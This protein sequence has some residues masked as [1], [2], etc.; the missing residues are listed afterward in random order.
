[1]PEEPLAPAD[2]DRLRRIRRRF[3]E[4]ATEYAALPL[5]ATVCREVARDEATASLL[6]AARPGQARPVLFLAALHELVLRRPDVAAAQWFPSVTGASGTVTGDPWPDVRRTVLAHADE[7]R[8]RIATHGTQTNE[9]NR[10]VYVAL[11]L[12]A[13]A[14]DRPGVPVAL[15]ELGASAGLLLGVDRYRVELV[16][17]GDPEPGRGHRPGRP[18]VVVGDEG[19]TVRCSGVDRAGAGEELAR[20]GLALPPVRG[21]VG[22]DLAPVDLADDDGVRWL[23]ACLWPEVPGRVERFRAAR[24]LLQ[25]DPPRVLRGDMV[26]R[27]P[28]AVAHARRSAGPDAHVVV[29][30]SWAVTYLEPTR[31]EALSRSVETLAAGVADLS[32][33]TAEPPGSAPGI[34]GPDGPVDG[35]TVVGL[36]RW[37]DGTELEPAVL[38]SC[39]PHGAWVDV[40]LDGLTDQTS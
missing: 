1:M 33:L 30:S 25:D 2:A 28:D 24:H 3:S 18:P 32:W 19:S 12:V 6:L 36:R 9:V 8:S 29:V 38:G 15:V 13:A 23:E 4:F 14:A 20:H 17:E 22:V 7:L 26:D 40:R 31:R 16:P 11:G 35:G 37:R 21:R 5:Y 10:A 39:H 27:L 34:A